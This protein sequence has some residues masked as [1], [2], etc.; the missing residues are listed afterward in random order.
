MSGIVIGNFETK[1]SRVG[2]RAP[3][4]PQSNLTSIGVVFLLLG[5]LCWLCIVAGKF[6][7]GRAHV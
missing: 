3:P 1:A 7:H 6:R 5:R 2:K 4:P